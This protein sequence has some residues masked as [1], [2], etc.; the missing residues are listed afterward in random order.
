[1]LRRSLRNIENLD[2]E[3]APMKKKGKLKED[4]D[5]ALNIFDE[6]L[7]YNP[8]TRSFL[9]M[10]QLLIGGVTKLLMERKIISVDDTDSIK[11]KKDFF[12]NI[13][14][15]D[16]S[17]KGHKLKRILFGA[18]D[19]LKQNW[20]SRALEVYRF[21]FRYR[22]DGNRHQVISQLSFGDFLS[23]PVDSSA[24]SDHITN[25]FQRLFASI[26]K[27]VQKL[28]DLQSGLGIRVKV[29]LTENAPT[30]YVPD[31]YHAS[32]DGRF[33]C[34][35]N[36]KFKKIIEHQ[37]KTAFHVC[38]MDIRVDMSRIKKLAPMEDSASKEQLKVDQDCPSDRED[39][40]SCDTLGASS[41]EYDD[42]MIAARSMATT[43]AQ[44]FSSTSSNSSAS[45]INEGMEFTIIQ[46]GHR[47]YSYSDLKSL[48]CN[49]PCKIKK[50]E[51][52]PFMICKRCE[53]YRHSCCFAFMTTDSNVQTSSC[54]ECSEGEG[55]YALTTNANLLEINN[56][57]LQSICVWRRLLLYCVMNLS[58][59]VEDLSVFLDSRKRASSLIKILCELGVVGEERDSRG[60][61]KVK[62]DKLAELC[63]MY[64]LKH[65]EK[66]LDKIRRTVSPLSSTVQITTKKRS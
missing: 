41:I 37:T 27:G 40:S 21:L 2:R 18:F 31:G 17:I 10:K 22:I 51:N 32:L 1:M 13:F 20:A 8:Q 3:V 11:I 15:P 12:I 23:S 59:S 25:E 39:V 56:Q 35:G 66:E 61:Q 34:Y 65:D 54:H 63:R 28:N 43:K 33:K 14:N 47:Y 38:Q 30:D 16:K 52:G 19:A 45:V 58:I 36:R 60:E 6:K 42:A 55:A 24:A 5:A 57:S 9:F 4:E 44:S 29:N 48:K 53:C 50:D 46:P 49:C 7:S 26:E 64:G 62:M